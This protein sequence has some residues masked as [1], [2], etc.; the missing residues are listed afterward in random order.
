MALR[1][2]HHP[3]GGDYVV[4]SEYALSMKMEDGRWEPAILYARVV[5]GPSGNW[6]YEGPNQFVTTK[7]RWA[8]RFTD[9]GETTALFRRP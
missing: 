7:V 6:Q 9:T 2:Y 5:R 1:I 4:M 3:D 8:E